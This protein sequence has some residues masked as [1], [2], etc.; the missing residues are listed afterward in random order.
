MNLTH[1]E[2]V[3][4]SYSERAV[5]VPEAGVQCSQHGRGRF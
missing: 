2:Q 4:Q 3:N 1:N 5:Q